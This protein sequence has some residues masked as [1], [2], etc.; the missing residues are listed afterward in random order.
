MRWALDHEDQLAAADP[1]M[2]ALFNRQA[3]NWRPLVGSN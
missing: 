1:D 2:G 3:D